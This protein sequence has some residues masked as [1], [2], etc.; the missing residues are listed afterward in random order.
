ME[1]NVTLG[2][3]RR[4]LEAIWLPFSRAAG[5]P[6]AALSRLR[7]SGGSN[8][9]SGQAGERAKFDTER[10]TLD[11]LRHLEWRRFEELCAAYFEALGFT[12]RSTPARAGGGADISVC[13]QASESASLIVHCKPWSAYRVGIKPVRELLGA[14]A[15]AGVGE[16]ALVSSGRFTQEAMNFAANE[17]IKLIDG[18]DLLGKLAAL[19]PEQALALLKFATRGDFLTPT[20]PGC[21]IKMISR[22]ST[23]EGRKYWGCPNYPQ[24][25][26]ILFGTAPG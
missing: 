21:S 4:A 17:N 10:W 20:C 24:C 13:A 16:G 3:A 15:S 14:M 2:I 1:R 8:G 12:T 22:R 7:R 6:V 11:L 25:K 23:A 26:E 18:A 9:E 5:A 19:P